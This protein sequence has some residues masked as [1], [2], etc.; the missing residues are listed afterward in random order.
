MLSYIVLV[1]RILLDSDRSNDVILYFI[2]D[3]EPLYWFYTGWLMQAWLL[4]NQLFN[5]CVMFCRIYKEGINMYYNT[6]KVIYMHYGI[7][8]DFCIHWPIMRHMTFWYVFYINYMGNASLLYV[9]HLTF[10]AVH[11]TRIKITELQV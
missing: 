10:I 7:L 11:F 6:K 4:T 9:L 1:H 8:V 3:S 2:A 5:C